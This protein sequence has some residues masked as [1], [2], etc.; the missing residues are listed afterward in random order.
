MQELDLETLLAA[1]RPGGSAALGSLTH[2]KP[3]AGP[4][5]PI[6]PAKYT[7][8][9]QGRE[10]EAVYVYEERYFDGEFRNTVLIKGREATANGIEDALALAIADGDPTLSL[11]PHI[12]VTYETQDGTEVS[13][14]DYTLPHRAF[15]AHIRLGKHDGVPTPQVPE[16]KAARNATPQDAWPLFALSP[17]TVLL[18]G[19]DST[20]RSNQAR[21]PSAITGEIVGVVEAGDTRAEEV[22]RSGAR[23]DPVGASVQLDS[24]VAAELAMGQKGEISAKLLDKITK[25]KGVKSAS[26]LGLGS[27]PP[28]TTSLDGIATS[29]IIRSYALSFSTL[30]RLRFGKGAEGDAAIRALLAALAIDG[31]VRNDAELFIRANCHLV[32]SGPTEMTLDLRQ[33][34]LQPIKPPTVEEADELLAAALDHAS[35]A[36]GVDWHGQSFNV[37][38]N[39]AVIAGAEANESDED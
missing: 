1:G 19:W 37:T 9:P 36:A 39:P 3:A 13:F 18:G 7:V 28:G 15:D 25:Q 8:K 20:R 5:A 32:E 33:G 17:V 14:H 34:N 29:D 38:G 16:Y 30:R 21:F 31:M 4:Q 24:S 12:T 22:R 27:I 11:L 6:S 26:N 35:A 10:S 2:L 23:L